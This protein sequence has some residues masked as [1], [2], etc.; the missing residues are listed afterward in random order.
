MGRQVQTAQT[1]VSL[2]TEES[3]EEHQSTLSRWRTRI[4]LEPESP[5]V[6]GHDVHQHLAWSSLRVMLREPFAE[7]FG[8]FIMVLFGNASVA[9]VLLSAGQTSAPGLNGF[10][11]YQSIN[12]RLDSYILY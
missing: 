1:N 2:S 6:D 10:G 7:F 9:Q 8:T 12:W 11:P 5:I 4:G 3:K